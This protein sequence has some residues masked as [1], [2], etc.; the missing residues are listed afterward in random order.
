MT[1]AVMQETAQSRPENRA[2]TTRPLRVVQVVRSLRTGGQEML[3]T[4]LVEGLEPARFD[5]TVL[6]LQGHGEAGGPLWKRIAARGVEVR[7]LFA[8]PA[9]FSPRLVV[10]LAR[11]LRGHHAN[12][13]H[14]HNFQPLLYAGLASRLTRGF[15]IVATAHGYRTW[16]TFRWSRALRSLLPRHVVAAVSPE[17]ATALAAR[18]YESELVLNGV[19]VDGL[20][21]A[22]DCAPFRAALGLDRD[23]WVVGAVGRLAAEKDH[24]TLL[25]AMRRVVDV[26]PNARLVVAGEGPLRGELEA[27]ARQLDLGDRARFLG[28]RSDVHAFLS[29]LDV[30]C[31]PSRTE[32]TSLSLLEAMAGEVPVVASAVG[33]TPSVVDGG[34]AAKLVPANDPEALAAALLDVRRDPEAASAR[35]ALG[36]RIVV[37]R[38]A[39]RKMVD[40][41]AELYSRVAKR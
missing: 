24:A 25:R 7:A 8:P 13:V 17:L 3:L 35:A 37:S 38:F 28:E 34:A 19:D 32:G 41:Y 10:D 40:R 31:L 14:A 1:A 30:F 39:L 22:E 36:R 12:V 6:V 18:G 21:R 27:L 15:P 29:A 4:R 11:A 26:E 9:G 20:A 33:G 2:E 5:T 16:G 23:A